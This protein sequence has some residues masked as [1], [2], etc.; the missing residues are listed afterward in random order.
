[1]INLISML[2]TYLGFLLILALITACATTTVREH[3][4]L[5]SQLLDVDSVLIVTP[6][7]TIEQINFSADNERLID[8]ENTIKNDLISLATRELTAR[9]FEVVDYDLEKAISED[10]NL[11]YAVNQAEEG[12]SE[13]KETLYEEQLSEEEKRKFQVSVGTAVN[14]ISEKSGADAVLLMH[15]IGYEKSAGYVA[16]DVAVGVL[17]GLLLGVVPTSG[18]TSS[19]VEVAFIDG[20]TG[21]VLWTNVFSAAT[22][23]LTAANK[24][25]EAFPEDIDSPDVSG[26]EKLSETE[27]Q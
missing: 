7:V 25:M 3:P 15:Y 18:N 14:I 9:G 16:K 21:D 11:A 20:V 19:Y 10:E 13:A 4:T 5:E 2:K 22:L 8:L 27:Q 24:A 12:F 23:D 6:A 1:M 26:P 17:S